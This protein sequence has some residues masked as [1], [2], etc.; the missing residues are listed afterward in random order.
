[1]VT[2][3]KNQRMDHSEALAFTYHSQLLNEE[4]IVLL[5]DRT[6]ET[7]K[8]EISLY[9]SITTMYEWNGKITKIRKEYVSDN[10]KH[11]NIHEHCA[12]T[13]MHEFGHV[14]HMRIFMRLGRRQENFLAYSWFL[15]YGYTHIIDRRVPIYH[16]MTDEDKL[17]MLKECFV[18]DYRMSLNLNSSNGMF[19]LPG[20]Y[21]FAADICNQAIL[22]EGVNTMRRMLSEEAME[23]E[24]KQD[25]TSI[26][27]QETTDSDLM[28]SIFEA[29]LS[30][31]W[32]PGE[33]K[34]TESEHHD[35]AFRLLFKEKK[36]EVAAA[37][38]YTIIKKTP[39]Q[40]KKH[41]SY[42][43]VTDTAPVISTID[44]FPSMGF[45]WINTSKTKI[46]KKK[47]K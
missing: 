45:G 27:E 14:L 2:R 46:S 23:P 44:D 3:F 35:V 17:W 37:L 34:M 22:V 33:S 1:M 13:L 10:L 21:T 25:G 38:P 28:Y 41:L 18:E 42:D 7:L 47:E 9:S 20:K 15:Q 12:Q 32:T 16:R 40:L 31:D 43:S 29:S 6:A 26:G 11:L 39:A 5:P 4:V 36:Q 8:D 19:I 24:R 30:D